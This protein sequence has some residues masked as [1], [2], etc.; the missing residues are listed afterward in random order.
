MRL[1]QVLLAYAIAVMLCV[2]LHVFGSSTAFQLTAA[3]NVCSRAGDDCAACTIIGNC[4]WCTLTTLSR[5]GSFV[6]STGQCVPSTSRCAAAPAAAGHLLSDTVEAQLLNVCPPVHNL[7]CLGMKVGDMCTVNEAYDVAV[8]AFQNATGTDNNLAVVGGLLQYSFQ[9]RGIGIIRNQLPLYSCSLLPSFLPHRWGECRCRNSTFLASLADQQ[10]PPP[11]SLQQLELLRSAASA[12]TRSQTS[13]AICTALTAHRRCIRAVFGEKCF[14]NAAVSV[15]RDLDLSAMTAISCAEACGPVLHESAALAQLRPSA[16]IC[17]R[18]NGQKCIVPLSYPWARN[19]G[20]ACPSNLLP[21]FDEHFAIGLNYKLVKGSVV[22]ELTAG[23][24]CYSYFFGSTG[25]YH[26]I[27][28]DVL[29]SSAIERAWP[30]LHPHTSVLYNAQFIDFNIVRSE[31][32]A[33]PPADWV[34]TFQL[35]ELA[36]SLGGLQAAL[37]ILFAVPCRYGFVLVF[38]EKDSSVMHLQATTH[39]IVR[40]AHERRLLHDLHLTTRF[41]ASDAASHIKRSTLVFL[42]RDLIAPAPFP[43]F[44]LSSQASTNNI[45]WNALVPVMGK[46]I[47]VY[48]S[49]SIS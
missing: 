3:V 48:M 32:H 13:D 14:T 30:R 43:L 15:C 47:R 6:T 23:N 5:N 20:Q 25:K 22:F 31:Q 44:L 26:W 39:A 9:T 21:V 49:P 27:V 40:M 19:T 29:G 16:P 8:E 18:A 35:A 33:T 11:P 41:T 7:P 46:H 28:T 42:K 37:D 38:G 10:C 24:T 2:M 17:A 1:Q 45:P 4:S 12:H 34:V 36:R